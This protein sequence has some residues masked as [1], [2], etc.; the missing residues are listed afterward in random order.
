MNYETLNY[1]IIQF[2]MN[3]KKAELYNSICNIQKAN[4]QF[5]MNIEELNL[6]IR[7]KILTFIMAM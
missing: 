6:T 3:I 5:D 7:K 1:E 4:I 2:D